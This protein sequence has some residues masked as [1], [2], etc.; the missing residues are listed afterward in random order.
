MAYGVTVDELKALMECRGME[1][2]ERIES[3]YGGTT[4]LCQKLSTDPANGLPEDPEEVKRRRQVFG[5]N[6]IPPAPSKSF[7]TLVWEAIQDVTL[8]ILL[9][10]SIVS[11]GLALWA[12]YGPKTENPGGGHDESENS[13][14]WIEGC[15]ILISVVVVV[16][17]TALNDW[18]KEKQFRGLQA[19][20]ETEHKFSVVRGGHSIEIIVNELVVGDVANVKYGDLL[21][22][23]GIIIQSNDLKIDESSL[24]GE[25]DLIKK[26][27][28][29]DPVLL[30]GTHVMEGSGKMLVTAVGIHSQTGIIMA[31]LGATKAE[32]GDKTPPKS[33]QNRA[34]AANGLEATQNGKLSAPLE[35]PVDDE[36]TKTKSVLQGKLSNLAIQIGYIGSV[37]AAATVIILVVRH[38]ITFYAVKKQPF[39]MSDVSYFVNFIIVGVTVLVIAVPE[40]LPLAITLALTYSVKKMMKDNNLVRHLD[41]CETMGN[42]TS[43][44]SDKTGT[45]TTNRMTVVQSFINDRFYREV[46]PT[47]SELDSKTRDLLLG[48]ICIN[49][50]YNSNVVPSETPGQLPTQVGNKSE[51]AMLQF[52]VELGQDYRAVRREHPEE[53]LVKVF[54]FNSARKSMMTVVK[55]EGGG[56]RVYSKGASE[57]IMARCKFILGAGGQVKPFGDQQYADINRS[58]IE[59][60]ASDGLRTMGLAFKDYVPGTPGLNEY[61]F[62][63]NL[64]LDDEESV[65]EGMTAIAIVGIQDPV[66]PEVRAAIEKCQR[67]GIT[68]RMVTGDNINTARSIATACGILKPG[69]DF[70]ALEGKEFN[71]RIR[72]SNGQVSQQK[73]D[74]IWP[75]L[76][77]LA[78][79]QPSDKY[80]LVKG[81][82]DSKATKNREV[83]AVTGDGTNDAPALKKA[84]VGF[85]MGIA[86]TD[87]A[88]EASDIILTDDNFTSIVKAVMWGRNVYDS[89][90]KF[91]QF[92]LTVN[93]VAVTIAFIGACAINDSPLR[94]V[95]MLWVN[96]IMDTLA[97]LA[98]ATEMPTE[99]LL[100]R[101]PYGRTKSLISRTMVKN[102]V[103]HALYQL[104]ILFGILFF[105]DKIVP[106]LPSGRW[107]ALGSPPSRHFTFIFNVF[108]LMTLC[109]ELNCRKIHGERNVF[110]GVF[111]NPIF[112]IIWFSTLILQIVIVEFGGKWFWTAPLTPLQWGISVA[113]GLGEF[114][115]GQVIA[116]IPGNVLP[117]FFSLGR[118]EVQPT[119]ILVTGEYDI[120]EVRTAAGKELGS[121]IPSQQNGRPG[122]ILW[123]LGLTR[124]QTQMRVV[125]A[126]QSGVNT[127][128][129]SSLTL[130]AGDRFRQ[131]YRRLRIA[132][133][134]EL[135]RLSQ[136]R[137]GGQTRVAPASP[138]THKSTNNMT[139]H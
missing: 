33:P 7:F 16:L 105:G 126:F 112:C 30:S 48:G 1:A 22:A 99:E 128:H 80:V 61:Q 71:A 85:A 11:L 25:S 97:S 76:R 73:L 87:V 26:S 60:M 40:G 138:T 121:V 49:S 45:L 12:M 137:A 135:E 70:L 77:V 69:A 95:Q 129:P 110:K 89:I 124:L 44:C 100:E 5:A 36:P 103:G 23:D 107:A 66:R 10:C 88:K 34:I 53:T 117:K 96:L 58:V 15:A 84:D 111:S 54:T 6:E 83:V 9:V 14:N 39:T 75:T 8:I 32:G 74:L 4:G 133:E 81:I 35:P 29:H 24:T 42:A 132:K 119:S 116:T 109:N 13:A 113:L 21:P 92:Q 134:R 72:D 2:K 114:I 3:D 50:G 115:W 91:L 108:V 125:R 65:R 27:P 37:V 57:I 123:L 98:L 51:C 28:E 41:A 130:D 56:Y 104:I 127:S 17:V 52:M 102:I 79:A 62:D 131:S 86:G 82:I 139:F 78:R 63:E 59:P 46:Q 19:K 38:C 31:L 93:V 101:K 68:V 67:A 47:W 94:A 90:A 18:T 43:I 136:L 20:I 55:R 64:N 118:G 106:D 120:P 122:Q